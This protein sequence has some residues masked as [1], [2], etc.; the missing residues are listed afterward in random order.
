MLEAL[1]DTFW[2]LLIDWPNAMGTAPCAT[3]VAAVARFR[4]PRRC[5]RPTA[6]RG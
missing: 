5:A 6:R 1:Q 3:P 4:S 2:H